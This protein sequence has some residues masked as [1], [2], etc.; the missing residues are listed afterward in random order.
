M[1]FFASCFLNKLQS[2]ELKGVVND[3]FV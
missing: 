1:A 2:Q 3:F